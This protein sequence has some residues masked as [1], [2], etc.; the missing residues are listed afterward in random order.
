MPSKTRQTMSMIMCQGIWLFAILSPR[1]R[2]KNN[3]LRNFWRTEATRIVTKLDD[4]NLMLS[5]THKN[6]GVYDVN[7]RSIFICKFWIVKFSLKCKF[8]KSTYTLKYLPRSCRHFSSWWTSSQAPPTQA[9]SSYPVSHIFTGMAQ[10][11]SRFI[12]MVGLLV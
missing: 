7:T 9:R 3:R 8:L 5:T 2:W 11:S 1:F 12:N 10:R 4:P 6:L